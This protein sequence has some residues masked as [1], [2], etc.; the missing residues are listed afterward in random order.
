[1][2]NHPAFFVRN[3][4]EYLDL[5]QSGAA[6]FFVRHPHDALAVAGLLFK[7]VPNPLFIRYWSM[8]PYALGPAAVKYSAVPCSREGF[9]EADRQ[10]DDYLRE[11]MIETLN[12]SDACFNFMVQLET[13]AEKMPIEDPT[14]KWKEKESP[15]IP[16]AQIK[17]QKQI[18][19]TDRQREFCENLSLTP[20]HSL[21]EHRPL[22]G[23]NRTRK[24]V[25]MAISK[26]RHGL[27]A[28]PR[29]EPVP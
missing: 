14:I 3:V 25:Y 27:N 23:I 29:K 18:F 4:D 26:L 13:D 12:S 16:V 11:S 28:A 10:H 7:K 21:P 5:N 19:D 1:M 24:V 8:T 17:I 9:K 2:I 6:S 22:G 15:F 20:W